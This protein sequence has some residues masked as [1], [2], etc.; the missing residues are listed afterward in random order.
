MSLTQGLVVIKK[1]IVYEVSPVIMP[2]ESFKSLFTFTAVELIA[3]LNLI[4]S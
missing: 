3:Q 2:D 4:S 1:I